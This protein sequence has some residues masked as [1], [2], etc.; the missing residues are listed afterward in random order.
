MQFNFEWDL[1]KAKSNL[2]KHKVSFDRASQIFLDPFTLS[3][4]DGAHSSDED[5]WITLGKD[6]NNV[7]LVVIHTYREVDE[8]TST[9]RIISARR[10]TKGEDKQYNSR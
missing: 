8:E 3:V 7:T 1:T 2:R 10:A 6:R 9:I 5:R 4:F